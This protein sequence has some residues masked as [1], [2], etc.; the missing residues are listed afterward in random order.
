M[1]YVREAAL[2]WT[3][4]ALAE[5]LRDD[6]PSMTTRAQNLV[7]IAEHYDVPVEELVA[8]IYR[9]AKGKQWTSAE[10]R[11]CCESYAKL[12]KNLGLERQSR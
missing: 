7:G 3:K 5:Q 4:R 6:S 8:W 10:W 12:R 11:R 9:E 2:D 1:S